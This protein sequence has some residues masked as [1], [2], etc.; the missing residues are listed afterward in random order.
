L[1]LTPILDWI[2]NRCAVRGGRA[3]LIREILTHQIIT[4][5]RSSWNKKDERIDKR[6]IP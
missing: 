1:S 6:I 4:T 2:T 5:Q 3:N